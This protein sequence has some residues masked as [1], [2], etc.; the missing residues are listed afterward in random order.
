MDA[1]RLPPKSHPPTPPDR[2]LPKWPE[3]LN[4]EKE[5]RYIWGA[6][7]GPTTGF[8]RRSGGSGPKELKR[9]LVDTVYAYNK[10]VDSQGVENCSY[11]LPRHSLD[12]R[13]LFPQETQVWN[14]DGNARGSGDHF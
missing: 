3:D 9:L 5:R 2:D 1:L 8:G 12:V 11:G 13:N 14:S 7:A 4:A 6:A 10:P